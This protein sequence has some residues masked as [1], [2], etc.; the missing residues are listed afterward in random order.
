MESFTCCKS[1]D[2]TARAARL[3]VLRPKSNQKAQV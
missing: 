1:L 2:P 3:R